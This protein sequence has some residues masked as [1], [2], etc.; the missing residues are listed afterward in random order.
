MA[1]TSTGGYIG[2]IF[3][4]NSGVHPDFPRWGEINFIPSPV[5][6]CPFGVWAGTFPIIRQIVNWRF[7]D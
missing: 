2:R 6:H 5:L 7:H 4:S 3:W 1:I